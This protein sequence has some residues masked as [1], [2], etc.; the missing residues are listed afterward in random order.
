MDR[1]KRTK[2]RGK[3]WYIGSRRGDMR[4]MGLEKEDRVL[5]KINCILL[6]RIGRKV[7]LGG[8]SY[9]VVWGGRGGVKKIVRNFNYKE[10]PILLPNNFFKGIEEGL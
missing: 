6:F 5:Q 7:L 3:T 10:A 8:G 9:S 2:E 1:Q 4:K